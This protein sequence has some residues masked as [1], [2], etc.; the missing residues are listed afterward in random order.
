MNKN[1]A[2]L[3]FFYALLV[4]GVLTNLMHKSWPDFLMALGALTVL[5]PSPANLALLKS[6]FSLTA[7]SPAEASAV[8]KLLHYCGLALLVIGL[9]LKIASL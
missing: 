5:L 8:G 1:N 9:C 6:K 2:S 4:S 7:A 3:V